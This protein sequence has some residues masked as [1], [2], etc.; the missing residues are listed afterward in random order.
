LTTPKKFH[1]DKRAAAIA[2]AAPDD[3]ELMTT[4]QTALWLAV[5]EQWLEIGRHR[6]YG[7]AY[8]RLGP[9]V[10]RYSRKNVRKW[11]D[12]RSHKSTREYQKRLAR[13]AHV[14][15]EAA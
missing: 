8:E 10:I 1:L 5:S 9:R 7:P 13:K 2:A 14:G 6:G 12:Q 15:G 4:R 11:L 3:D